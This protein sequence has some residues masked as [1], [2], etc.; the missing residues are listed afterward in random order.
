MPNLDFFYTFHIH[1]FILFIYVYIIVCSC[2]GGQ[3]QLGVFGFFLTLCVFPGLNSV[4][5]GNKQFLTHWTISSGL[6]LIFR[7]IFHNSLVTLYIFFPIRPT[8]PPVS[9]LCFMFLMEVK[10]LLW[11]TW[12]FKNIHPP[13]PIPLLKLL[14]F[15][16]S[17]RT[18]GH[19]FL[20]CLLG[21]D[22][23]R[24]KLHR[25]PYL[26]SQKWKQDRKVGHQRTPISFLKDF[27]SLKSY[28]MIK[29]QYL[30]C[31]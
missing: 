20:L 15:R 13:T 29:D 17:G 19:V 28:F 26:P 5:L 3:K 9:H 7:Y 1:L 24:R 23:W 31:W 14:F 16:K 11:N 21:T 4:R 25:P 12:I 8:Y 6:N 10:S 30:V 22:S 2:S 27:H 18:R